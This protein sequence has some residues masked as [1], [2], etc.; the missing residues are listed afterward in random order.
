MAR[1]YS[2]VYKWPQ[3]GPDWNTAIALLWGR[4]PY[5]TD[6]RYWT[7]TSFMAAFNAENSKTMSEDALTFIVEHW[8]FD[9]RRAS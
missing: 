8:D 1:R 9:Q 6:P 5:T 7:A 2:E 3:G 4:Q